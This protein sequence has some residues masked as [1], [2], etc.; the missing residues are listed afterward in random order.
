MEQKLKVD[1]NIE[2]KSITYF[3]SLILRQHFNEHHTFEL[4]FNHDMVEQY[5]FI[6]IENSKNFLGKIITVQFGTANNSE[7]RF[8]GFVTKVELVQSEGFNGDIIVSGYSQDI[9]LERGPGLGSYLD[10]SLESILK[11][12]SRET[13][14][15]DLNF[16]IRPGRKSPVDYIMQYKES[17]FEFINRLSAEYFEWFYYDGTSLNFG[18]PD[19]LEEISLIYGR[20][21]RSLQYAS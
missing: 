12:V 11:E 14:Q 21:L 19:K 1:I 16:N 13:A 7:N 3:S 17:D 15:N 9:I 20:D 6:T 10:K 4:R 5:S 8:I 2:D 18:K